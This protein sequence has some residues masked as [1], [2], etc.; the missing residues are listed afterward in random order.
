MKKIRLSL[1][2]SFLMVLNL[3]AVAQNWDINLL[4]S[5]NQHET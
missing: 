2:V 3:A 5:I 1:T 4:K